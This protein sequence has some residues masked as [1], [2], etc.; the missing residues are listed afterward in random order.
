MEAFEKSAPP[1]S[2]PGT[3]GNRR[4]STASS[5]S[6]GRTVLT[7]EA[8]GRARTA[9]EPPASP[10]SEK[11]TPPKSSAALRETIAKAKAARRDAMK[12]QGKASS[13][14]QSRVNDLPNFEVGS[15]EEGLGTR[16]AKARSDGRLH[17]AAMGLKEMPTQVLNMY[18]SDAHDTTDGA[19]YESVDLVKVIA[20]DNEIEHLDDRFFPDPSVYIENSEGNIFGGLETLDLHGNLLPSLP[21]GLSSLTRLITLNVSKNRLSDES[22]NV[23]GKVHS[24]RE[25]RVADNN[26]KEGLDSLCKMP[27]LEILDLSNNAF[28]DLPS[29][30]N[31][32]RA[33]HTLLVSRNEIRTVPLS[34]FE[35]MSLRELN[36][37]QNRLSGAF[38]PHNLSGLVTIKSLDVSCNALATI[39]DRNDFA[40]P[41]LQ[42]FNISEN[43]IIHLPDLSNWEELITLTAG[44]NRITAIPDG[45]TSLT[46]LRN[47]DLTR[48]DIKKF[49]ERLGVMDS[50]TALRIANNPLRERKFLTMATDDLKRE[51][52]SR[53][54][55]ADSLPGGEHF[56]SGPVTNSNTRSSAE[57]WPVQPG[58]ILDRSS[59]NLQTINPSDLEPILETTDIK[60]MLLHHNHLSSIP[61]AIAI[62]SVNLTTLDLSHNKFSPTYLTETEPLSLPQLKSL[63]LTANTLKTLD[64]LI[65]Y[66]SSPSLTDLTLNRNRL[67]TLPPLHSTFPALTTVL[68]ADNLISDLPVEAVRGLQVLDASGNDIAHL[69]PKLGLLGKA[70][71]R[72]LVVTGNRFRVPRREMVEKGT[73]AV[74]RWLRGRI[75]DGEG[76]VDEE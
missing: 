9:V 67:T 63:D 57:L 41:S 37:S 19:W 51:L 25:L 65:N 45:L 42:T 3:G 75:T 36:M 66:L 10:A 73:E 7:S 61:R 40:M 62:L 58:G 71:L 17:I 72:T 35:C 13:K 44:G 4:I 38:F 21:R 28:T 68:A 20:A 22:L 56:D 32:L 26:L 2:K 14:V 29:D 43:R 11:S 30:I 18:N 33:L 16:I 55:P 1:V 34:V 6:S 53:L 24:L 27:A 59:T 39:T 74:L 50:L 15:N 46:K 48:N 70:G 47:V 64:P 69:E 54:L 8:N 23:L 60:T 12:H 31:E 5:A 76:E 49:D 52:R